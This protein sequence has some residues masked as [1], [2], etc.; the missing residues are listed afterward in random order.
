MRV[1]FYAPLKHPGHPVPS[2]DR[3][4][5]RLLIAA[6]ETGG[7][8]VD[9]ASQLRSF[10]G[11]GD[12]GA[13]AGIR[14]AAATE[15]DRLIA[16]YREDPEATRPEIWFTYHVYYKAPDWLGPTVAAA[17]QIPYMT[18]EASYA[19]KRAGGAWAQGH[20]QTGTALQ[21]GAVHLC[22]TGF[23]RSAIETFLG[24]PDRLMDLPPFLEAVP[25]MADRD[26]AG[27]RE[28][29]CR[30]AGF[31]LSVPIVICAAMMRPGDKEASYR[32]LASALAGI[33]DLD[34][35]LVLVG[36]GPVRSAVEEAFDAIAPER[37]HWAGELGSEEVAGHLAAADIY[38]WPACNE[39]Y[40]MAFLEA[41]AV[42]LPV[43]AQATRGVPD[44]VVPGRSAL[45]TPEGDETAFARAL[46][47]L[48]VDPERRRA[49]GAAARAFV[50]GERTI[51]HATAILDRALARSTGR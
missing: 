37:I 1:A 17:L 50:A 39:A 4:M 42:G 31:D 11:A 24:G 18:A 34:W 26:K 32:M 25:A 14:A 49:M 21:A 19:P 40:G 41:Q 13:Q 6:L 43:V 27:C 44:V 29:L 45:L 48:I 30:T 28:E 36:D 5:A 8:E 7:H 2:G 23:D 20:E 47:D 35:N 16:R 38:A 9:V 33:A 15:A 10:E 3:R 51:T 12:R 46:R 22:L